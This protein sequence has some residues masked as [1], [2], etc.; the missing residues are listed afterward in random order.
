MSIGECCEVGGCTYE[1]VTGNTGELT[2][3]ACSSF[4]PP[5]GESNETFCESCSSTV[6]DCFDDRTGSP[7]S[8]G[9][10]FIKNCKYNTP[11]G[12]V[13]CVNPGG[14]GGGGP[15]GP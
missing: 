1:C 6:S 9:Q 10:S 8:V 14:G 15:G 2:T 7:V 12:Q 3:D 11:F 4:V 5:E 13:V